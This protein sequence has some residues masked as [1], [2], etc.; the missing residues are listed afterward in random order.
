MFIACG[1]GAYSV[2]ILYLICHAFFKSILFLAFAYLIAAMSGEK[3]INRMGGIAKIAPKITCVVWT[4][5]LFASGFPLLTGFF[6]KMALSEVIKN[7]DSN[8]LLIATI[9]ASFLNI[10]AIFRMLF[11]SLYGETK[12]DEM[13]FFRA[14]KSNEYT[15][16]PFWSLSTISMLV[17]FIVWNIFK[18]GILGFN[19]E[20]MPYLP[21]NHFQASINILLQIIIAISLILVF[22]KHTN[23]HTG[24]KIAFWISRHKIYKKSVTIAT[25][26]IMRFAKAFNTWSCQIAHAWN[27]DTFKEIYHAGSF[28]KMVHVNYLQNHVVW[29]LCGL[30]LCLIFVFVERG[31]G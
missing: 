11:Q 18:E 29:I 24:E 14:S 20:K 12:A 15:F 27:V 23:N 28:L 17:S 25:N 9:L 26:M 5:F 16:A 21:A 13:T 1:L 31:L 4:S 6:P 22:E 30:T 2:A 8:I 7:T 10:I 3:N 19:E